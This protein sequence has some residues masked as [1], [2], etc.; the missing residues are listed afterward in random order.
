MKP[1]PDKGCPSYGKPMQRIPFDPQ[2]KP[3]AVPYVFCG[4]GDSYYHAVEES[5]GYEAEFY[6]CPL[7][8]PDDAMKGDDGRWY[9]IVGAA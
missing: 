8:N 3:G 7:G 6:R 1:Q 2:P 4:K 5:G 9:W